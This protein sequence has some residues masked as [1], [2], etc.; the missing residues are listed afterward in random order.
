MR[1]HPHA[2]NVANALLKHLPQPSPSTHPR[3]A[4]LPGP[5][6]REGLRT[7]A[8]CSTHPRYHTARSP[9]HSQPA[10]KASTRARAGGS[11]S[12]W[13][14]SRATRHGSASTWTRAAPGSPPG[15]KPDRHAQKFIKLPV[16]SIL[17]PATLIFRHLCTDSMCSLGPARGRGSGHFTCPG[18]GRQLESWAQSRCIRVPG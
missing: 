15:P 6:V 1:S 13:H 10:A 9:A 12:G 7:C 14:S 2:T 3:G 8:H 5:R 16:V 18:R 11:S 4:A 17:G